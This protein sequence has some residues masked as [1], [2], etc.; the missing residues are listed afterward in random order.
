MNDCSSGWND[1]A[2]EQEDYVHGIATL[3]RREPTIS[4]EALEIELDPAGSFDTISQIG[5][6]HIACPMSSCPNPQLAEH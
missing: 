6:N 3:E 2:D 5:H 1:K 4:L